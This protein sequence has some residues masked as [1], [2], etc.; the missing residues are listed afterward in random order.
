[1]T[2][3]Y[4]RLPNVE[5]K[6]RELLY[7]VEAKHLSFMSDQGVFS[8]NHVDMGTDLL[9][10]TVVEDLRKRGVKR[11]KLLDLGCGIGVIGIALKRLIPPL[12]LTMVDVNL[13]A[14]ELT[15]QNMHRNMV[16]YGDVMES[17]GFAALEGQFFDV[18]VTNPPIRAGKD[19]V[20]RFF[21]DAKTHLNPGGAFYCVVGK[22]QGS[23]SAEKKLK[24][25]FN[26]V[27]VLKKY[28]GFS[29]FA[30]YTEESEVG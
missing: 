8:K 28:K 20:Y 23:P 5:S 24:D 6:P 16:R 17:D 25:V 7:D 30:C 14:L 18:V 11:G 4:E 9:I 21:E 15:E 26:N 12:E 22:K 27:T 3:Y 2:H 13:R 1:M 19:V 29:I 10:R